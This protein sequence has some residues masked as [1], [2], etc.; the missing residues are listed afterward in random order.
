M[1]VALGTDVD[2]VFDPVRASLLD[3]VLNPCPDPMLELLIHPVCDPVPEPLVDPL[4]ADEKVGDPSQSSHKNETKPE[5]PMTSFAVRA[6]ITSSV[7]TEG[8][9]VQ[10]TGIV[11]TFLLIVVVMVEQAEKVP[12]G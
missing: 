7:I 4:V 6:T 3:P 8:V 10:G 11:W 12:V 1:K 5:G 2:P 9:V